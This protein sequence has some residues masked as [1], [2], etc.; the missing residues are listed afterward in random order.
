MAVK[1][2][3]FLVFAAATTIS[4]G[5]SLAVAND[6]FTRPLPNSI[7]SLKLA[8]PIRS[9]AVN[10]V[11][12]SLL[13]AEGSQQI[14]VRLASPAVASTMG[15]GEFS[16]AASVGHKASLEMEQSAF[17]ARC[18]SV[19]PHMRVIAQTQLVLNAVFIEVDAAAIPLIAKDP[20]V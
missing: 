16:A 5:T 18:S 19:A 3:A 9:Q 10:K 14:I 8:E 4:L 17:L 6:R 12:Q 2:R 20:A 13:A 15:A 7:A 1:S 11:D